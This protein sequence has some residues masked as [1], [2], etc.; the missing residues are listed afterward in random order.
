MVAPFQAPPSIHFKAL[1]KEKELWLLVVVGILY[2]YR[3]LFSGETFFFRDL[4]L[5]FF[6]Q[7]QLL[8]DF[9]KAGEFP[10]WDP[11]LH[12]GQPYFADISNH[13]LYPFNLLYVLFPLLR[14][15]NLMIVAH[16]LLC[17]VCAYLFSRSIG[18]RPLSSLIAGMVYGFCGYTLS[19]ANLLAGF[20]AM[21]YLPLS[22]LYWHCYLREGKRKWFVLSIVV[23]VIRVFAGSP[24]INVITFGALLG[25]TLCYPYPQVTL[26]RK[27]SLW[28]VLGIFIVGI[29]SV[30]LFPTIEMALQ[31]SRGQ[32]MAYAVFSQWSLF[33]GRLA[34]LVLP[35]FFGRIDALP[36]T[37]HYWG[38]VVTDDGAPYIISIYVGLVTMLLTVMGGLHKGRDARLPFRVRIF[39]LALVVLSVLLALGRF[40]PGFPF[41][42]Q[43]LPGIKLFRFPIKFLFLGL[44]PIALLAGYG[45]E[46]HFASPA[47]QPAWV[48]SGKFLAVLW[49][50]FVILLS[51]TVR[52]IYSPH[53]AR[54][55]QELF[56]RQVG[57]D[58]VQ[59]GV[60]AS[61][62][63]ALAFWTLVTLLYQSCRLRRRAWQPWA[64]VVILGSDLLSAGQ[65]VN[66][67]APETFFTATPEIVPLVRQELGDGRLF[68]AP[69]PSHS[70]LRVP[71]HEVFWLYRWGLEVLKMYTAALYR[72]PVIFHDDFDGMAALPLKDLLWFVRSVYL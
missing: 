29:A 27:L 28:C 67:Y 15:F 61:F 39:L 43:Y 21:P 45:V 64:L 42:Y 58:L 6:P 5:I 55:A 7:K 10:L 48:P 53:F 47:S 19:L 50:I 63:H 31:S 1:L 2:F 70:T 66:V 30:Q 17:A 46:I 24:E 65:A 13:A 34:E 33:P 41:L 36:L 51:L 3:P 71:S 68:R 26:C 56:F 14:A 23:G 38:H 72:I 32:G 9:I 16:L 8:T 12:G 54:N 25:W 22:F 40:L 11:Y 18:L 60:V 49:G 59:Q 44:F 4:C 62:V 69:D 52:L 37:Q 35:G 57:G 20:L